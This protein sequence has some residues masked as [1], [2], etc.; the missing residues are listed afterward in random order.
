[1]RWILQDL[2]SFKPNP[3]P[4]LP[5]T[6]SMLF[7]LVSHQ[8]SNMASKLVRHSHLR[9]LSSSI[10][11]NNHIRSPHFSNP[12]RAPLSFSYRLFSNASSSSS[13]GGFQRASSLKDLEL[14]KFASIAETWSAFLFPLFFFFSFFLS[15]VWLVRKKEEEEQNERNFN[16]KFWIN[17]A[18][19]LWIGGIQKGHLSHCMWW[20]LQGLLSFAPLFVDIW[21]KFFCFTLHVLCI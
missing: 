6:H 2:L 9:A 20:I 15:S 8:A 5:K 1:M 21:G 3:L 13:T 19:V 11:I 4:F 17:L 16:L 14:P 10:S 18:S 7:V 12:N